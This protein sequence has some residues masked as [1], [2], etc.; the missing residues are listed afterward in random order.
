[1]TGYGWYLGYVQQGLNHVLEAQI[2]PA[3]RAVKRSDG[4][5]RLIIVPQL[6]GVFHRSTKMYDGDQDP[7][8]HLALR[9]PSPSEIRLQYMI[10]LA[11]GAAG[12]LSYP[13]GFDS[14]Y[15]AEPQAFPGLVSAREGGID[16]NSNVDTIYG[17]D[18]V[19][20]GYREKWTE[21]VA[22]HRRLERIEGPLSQWHWHSAKSW[23]MDKDWKPVTRSTPG[24][25]SD[26]V[27][28]VA[29]TTRSKLHDELSQVEVG[30]L[31]GGGNEY[32]VVVN[33]RTAPTDVARISV[34]IGGTRTFDVADIE[35]PSSAN[36]VSSGSTLSGTYLPGDAKIYRLRPRP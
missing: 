28:D 13:Y 24:W 11:Y 27:T 21:V 2:R 34:K 7:H 15:D 33:R 5:T 12:F 19:W 31:T 20:T 8:S 30:Y 4:A 32:L 3:A 6:H 22:L 29:V 35:N 36:V 18:N 1:M 23:T 9:P 25:P 26:L 14:G 16:H 17:A 10:G